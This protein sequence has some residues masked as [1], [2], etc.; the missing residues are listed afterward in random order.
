MGKKDSNLFG[1]YKLLGKWLA[2]GEFEPTTEQRVMSTVYM[3]NLNQSPYYFVAETYAKLKMTA[4]YSCSNGQKK[5]KLDGPN[6]EKFL[7]DIEV[8]YCKLHSSILYTY[9]CS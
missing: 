8:W 3:C 5:I 6:G 9:A 1:S 4:I 2:W 7:G